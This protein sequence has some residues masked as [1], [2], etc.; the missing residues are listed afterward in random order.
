MST[1]NRNRKVSILC[2]KCG[3]VLKE[4]IPQLRTNAALICP[5]CGPVQLEAGE[6]RR[7]LQQVERVLSNLE[8]ISGN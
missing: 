8:H 3:E 5:V 4:T 1:L 7:V 2:P 6:L